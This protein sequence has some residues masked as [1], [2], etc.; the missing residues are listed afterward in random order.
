VKIGTRI[1][2]RTSVSSF[3]PSCHGTFFP[4]GNGSR[5]GTMDDIDVDDD[6]SRWL[7]CFYALS[8]YE[9]RIDNMDESQGGPEN[10]FTISII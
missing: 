3:V 7:L 2:E 10:H 8:S 9:G 4:S 6:G 1:K 5:D